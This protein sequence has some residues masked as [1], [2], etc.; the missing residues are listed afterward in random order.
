[1]G[2]KYE[3]TMALFLLLTLPNKRTP[4]RTP[5]YMRDMSILH[6]MQAGNPINPGMKG[7]SVRPLTPETGVRFPVGSPLK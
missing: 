1:M 6:V 4:D 2:D 5:D 3:I 7:S